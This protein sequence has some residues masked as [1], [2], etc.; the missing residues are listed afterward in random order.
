M[1]SHIFFQSYCAWCI[2]MC[3]FVTVNG[4]LSGRGPLTGLIGVM[5]L[6]VGGVIQT[7]GTE[8]LK[9]VHVY[10]EY[11]TGRAAVMLLTHCSVGQRYP[12]HGKGS[13]ERFAHTQTHI[14]SHTA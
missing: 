11:S 7:A 14:L 12:L 3:E 1:I 5:V 13:Y 8:R 4:Q 10:T 6:C 2:V 9:P